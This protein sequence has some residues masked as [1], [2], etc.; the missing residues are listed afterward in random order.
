MSFTFFEPS[1]SR[2]FVSF[3]PARGHKK[4]RLPHRKNPNDDDFDNFEIDLVKNSHLTRG[5]AGNAKTVSVSDVHGNKVWLK[6]VDITLKYGA[7]DIPMSIGY[8]IDPPAHPPS[9]RP[10]VTKVVQ[11]MASDAG[12][13]SGVETDAN[14]PVDGF[15]KITATIGGGDKVFDVRTVGDLKLQP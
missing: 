5:L 11:V 3:P 4:A 10:P 12:P 9:N 6:L 1:Q 13:T 15:Y 7:A 8:E 2:E 14:I